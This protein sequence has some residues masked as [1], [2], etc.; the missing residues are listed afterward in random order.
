MK[1]KMGVIKVIYGA[2]QSH[3]EEAPSGVTRQL[4]GAVRHCRD[5]LHCSPRPSPTHHIP[6]TV[7][8]PTIGRPAYGTRSRPPLAHA[9]K[10]TRLPPH[11]HAQPYIRG[12][13]LDGLFYVRAFF[14][15]R[16][17]GVLRPLRHAFV[18][19]PLAPGDTQRNY[20]YIAKAPKNNQK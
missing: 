3:F 20:Y 4:Y 14:F 19:H 5:S 10:N 12:T 7:T 18:Q 2:L 1:M 6:H 8:S 15:L 11:S 9:R 13:W 17:R 16:S